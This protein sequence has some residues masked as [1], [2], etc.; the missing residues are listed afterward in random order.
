M[1]H[2]SGS[3]AIRL[4]QPSDQTQIEWLYRRTP[5]AGQVAWRDMRLPDDLRVIPEHFIAFFVAVER[6]SDTT[7]AIVGI[8]GVERAG[9]VASVPPV[10]EFLDTTRPTARLRHVAVAPERWRLGIGARLVRGAIDWSRKAG[11]EALILETTPQQEAVVRLYEA[12]DFA[13]VGRSRIGGHDLI[14]FSLE[15]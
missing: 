1:H 10:P 2:A 14:W 6:V 15:L 3:I 8:T 12:M 5:P 13:D 7:E 9:A 4:Y 11:F